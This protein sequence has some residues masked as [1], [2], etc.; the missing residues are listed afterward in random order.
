MDSLNRIRRE[1]DYA[2]LVPDPKAAL[3]S[4]KCVSEKCRTPPAPITIG[5]PCLA[6]LKKPHCLDLDMVSLGTILGGLSLAAVPIPSYQYLIW[7]KTW[8]VGTSLSWRIMEFQA[9]HSAKETTQGRALWSFS[10]LSFPHCLKQSSI[11]LPC[12]D[13]LPPDGA[14]VSFQACLVKEQWTGRWSIDSSTYLHKT[15]L[16]GRC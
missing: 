11:V 6:P 10:D 5:V 1:F 13:P 16:L 7:C 4:R 2:Q 9:N 3:N 15:H 14:F 8:N 12:Q